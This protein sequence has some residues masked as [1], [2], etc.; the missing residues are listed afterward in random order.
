MVVLTSQDPHRW[1]FYCDDVLMQNRRFLR[2]PHGACGD[3]DDD[4][5]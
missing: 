2:R 5:I 1:P 3:D 4:V